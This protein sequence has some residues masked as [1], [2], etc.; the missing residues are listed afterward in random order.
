MARAQLAA[1]LSELLS[2]DGPSLLRADAFAG[3]KGAIA[4]AQPAAI[5]AD[6]LGVEESVSA[7]AKCLNRPVVIAASMNCS[8]RYCFVAVGFCRPGVFVT[9]CQVL[10]GNHVP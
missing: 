3:T 7:C 8:Y 9:S 10:K 6:V 5:S 2:R 1:I 4:T